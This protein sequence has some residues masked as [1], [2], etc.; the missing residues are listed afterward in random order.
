MKFTVA[1]V[2]VPAEVR[3]HRS[4]QHQDIHSI[5]ASSVVIRMLG[6]YFASQAMYN[7]GSSSSFASSS[8]SSPS[9]FSSSSFSYSN[10]PEAC[11]FSSFATLTADTVAVSWK[12]QDATQMSVEPGQKLCIHTRHSSGDYWLQWQL[13]HPKGMHSSLALICRLIVG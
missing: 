7:P 10:G 4:Y 13:N 5:S 6:S 11:S 12:G 2:C 9:L 8:S 1:R 3:G